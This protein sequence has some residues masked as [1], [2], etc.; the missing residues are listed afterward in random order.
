MTIDRK[1]WG[2]KCQIVK[3]AWRA[4]RPKELK[5]SS[6]LTAQDFGLTF[7]RGLADG[8][9]VKSGISGWQIEDA[10]WSMRVRIAILDRR[11]AKLR[12]EVVTTYDTS[13]L[14]T[15]DFDVLAAAAAIEGCDLEPSPLIG[16]SSSDDHIR[17]VVKEFSDKIDKIWRFAHGFTIEGLE[18]L[19]IWAIRNRTVVGMQAVDIGAIST[20]FVYGERALS[21]ELLREYEFGLEKRRHSWPVNEATEAI[22]AN[23]RNEVTRLRILLS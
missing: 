20:A 9:E 7:S 13:D 15:L 2:K 19:S 14:T 16:P 1:S 18:T 23:L 4:C 8:M 3:H 21:D 10:G 22:Y 11:V 6:R 12:S 17:L 5:K